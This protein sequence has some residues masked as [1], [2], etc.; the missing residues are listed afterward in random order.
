M[1]GTIPPANG[2]LLR[3]MNWPILEE[4]RLIECLLHLWQSLCAEAAISVNQ[5][6]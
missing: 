1:V 6:E 4:C 5:A 2:I 3:K